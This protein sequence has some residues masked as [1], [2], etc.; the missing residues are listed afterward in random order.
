MDRTLTTSPGFS[1]MLVGAVVSVQPVLLSLI[2]QLRLEVLPFTMTVNA[3]ESPE[4]G[5]ALRETEKLDSVPPQRTG[6]LPFVDV[7]LGFV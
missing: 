6:A 7:L 2:V 4:L 3:Y 1:A 5:A